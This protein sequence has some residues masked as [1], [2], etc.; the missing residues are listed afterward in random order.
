MFDRMHSKKVTQHDIQNWVMLPN[1]TLESGAPR[2]ISVEV[3]R[4]WLHSMGFEVRAVT[5][6]IY[7]DGHEHPDVI[8][9]REGFLEK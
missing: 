4:K 7:F 2:K 5:K 3:A 6:G 9:A 8:E 1:N